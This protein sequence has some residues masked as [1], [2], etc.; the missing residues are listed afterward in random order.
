MY[1]YIVFSYHYCRNNLEL[2]ISESQKLA[3]KILDL[4]GRAIKLDPKEME[5]L[6]DNGRQAVRLNYYP[7]CPQ[8][9]MVMGLSPHSD[10]TGITMLLQV[11]EV[12]GLQIRKD[13]LW[14]PV[15]VLPDAIV[16]NVGDILEVN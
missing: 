2:Y 6:F 11:N 14:F 15:N 8:S 4:M 9:D 12:D 3:K 13:G 10:P 16:V 7:P 1:K 5:E